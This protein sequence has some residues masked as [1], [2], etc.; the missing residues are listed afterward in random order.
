MRSFG[1]TILLSW[2]ILTSFTLSAQTHNWNIDPKDYGYDCEVNAIVFMGSGEVNTGT[3]G[4]FVGSTCRGFADGIY[5]S[6]TGKTIFSVRCYSD[7]TLLETITFRYFNPADNSYHNI[8]ETVTFVPDVQLGN[9][10]SPLLFHRCDPVVILSQPLNRSMCAVTGNESF[11]VTTGGDSP[12]TYQWQ[13][14]TGT[15]WINVANGAPTGAI[16]TGSN[17]TLLGL[18]GITAAGNYQYRCYI[19]NCHEWSN[20]TSNSATL[21]VNPLPSA[22]GSITGTA[23]VC[24]GNSALVYYVSAITNATSYIWTLPSGVTGTS[25]TNTITVNYSLTAVSGNITVRGHNDCGDGTPSLLAVT[26]NPLPVAASSISGPV[27]VCQGQTTVGYTVPAITN[28]ASY[29]WSYSGTGAVI[30]NGTTNSI[31]IDLATNATSGNLTVRGVNACGQG[32]VSANYPITVNPLPAAAGNI[33][34]TSI[35]CQGETSVGYSLSLVANA[36]SYSWT[37]SG[38]GA[39][40]NGTT[41][42][43]QIDFANNATSGI[44]TVRG[45]NA[46]GTGA[47]S[48][49]FPITVN[50]LPGTA[51]SITGPITICQGQSSVGY[52]VSSIA[53]AVSYAWTYSGTGAAINGT[54]NTVTIDF[55][56]TATP[57]NLIVRG[58]N[59]CGTGIASA[60]YPITVNLLPVAAGTITGLTT[61]CQGQSPVTY[62]VPAITNATTYIWTLPSGV[63]GTSTTNSITVSY[64]LSAISGNVSV[65]G[66]NACGDGAASALAVTV[67]PLPGAAGTMTGLTAVCQGQVSVNYTVPLIPNATTYIWTLP[68]GATGTSTTNSITVN[69]GLA[70]ISG[71]ITVRGHNACG[72][73]TL[74]T[75]ALTVNP[76]PLAAG[77]ITGLTTVCQGQSSVT[78]SV[79]TITN[80]ASYVWTVPTGATGTSTTNSIT[81]SYGINAISGNVTVRGHNACGDGTASALA[82]TVNPL[83]Q[84]AGTITGLTSVC[85]GQSL[86]T[87]TVPIITNATSYVWTLPSGSTGTS[88]TNSISVSYSLTA[89]SGNITVR[90][91]NGCGDGTASALAVTVNHLPSAI[92]GGNSVCAGSTITLG[93]SPTGGTW[94]SSVP[95]VAS[96]NSSTGLVAGVSQG[97]SVI[98][99]QLLSGCSVSQEINVL[100]ADW[101]F[102][103]EDFDYDGT[104]TALINMESKASVAGF[105]AAY[106]GDDCRGYAG[107]TYYSPTGNYIFKLDCFSNETTE[108]ILT[109]KYFD[110]VKNVVYNLDRSVNFAPGMDVGTE[111][112]PI[113]MEIGVNLN[114]SF[115]SGWTWF[116]VNIALDNMALNFIL[117]SV[118]TPG[119]YIKSQTS[120]ATYYAGYGWFGS[121]NTIEPTKLYKIKVQNTYAIKFSG[122]PVDV[123]T[124]P[125]SLSSGWNWIGY[126][127][128][129]S[130][131]LSTALASLPLANNDYIKDQFNSSTYYSIISDW[132]GNLTTMSPAAGYM[133][134]LT[135]SGTLQYP[136]SGKKGFDVNAKDAEN[137]YNANEFEF[138]GSL[139]VKVMLDGIAKGSEN[140]FLYAYVN[141]EIRG[142][143]GGDYFK[144]SDTW[145]YSLML[146]SNTS[147]GE[148]VKFRYFDSNSNKYYD[149]YETITFTSDMVIADALKPLELNFSSSDVRESFGED[150]KLR[151]YPNPFGQDLNI[152]YDLKNSCNVRITILDVYG[153][154]IRTLLDQTQ[155]PDN[156]LF[157]WNSDLPSYGIYF[158]RFEAGQ[159]HIIQKVIVR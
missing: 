75:L 119:D 76:L 69:Y 62:S 116:S 50:P 47:I 154:V 152:E 93:S 86:V 45:V 83:P 25:S 30:N 57:G 71:I 84:T 109:F 81:V 89:V 22:A 127:P 126:L 144:P 90:G 41:N 1:R 74:S 51:T 43:I 125:I 146:H 7:T 121:L 33:S 99:Y 147:Q 37:Y 60:S 158:I 85:R 105:L 26:V 138:N 4:A 20:L 124:T 94:S 44:L 27:S 145:L 11:S 21:T 97:V 8:D 117:S 18:S 2:L 153:R 128:Q 61:V 12:F 54:T 150:L 39:A 92:S 141:N 9:A 134:R 82:V 130:M 104:V 115:P 78:Y 148:I 79:P 65:R 53:N 135:N 5:F 136:E 107:S 29:S 55:S 139:T 49:N 140:D 31:I 48:A 88:I 132:F 87:Y 155:G 64:G 3:L 17:T 98:T 80:A 56:A 157:R 73:G 151:T 19:T 120:S 133:L 149:C 23:I 34:G 102:I 59:A 95:A 100:P 52:G 63:T 143:I 70:A 159:Q 111:S 40:I 38:N 35:V 58:V 108:D 131:P 24:Q 96:V 66:H 42:N 14:F 156:Y 118:A 10:L 101:S 13:Y 123:G 68:A 114:M 77:I 16:Y 72:D 106:S 129:N 110:P 122:K 15:D 142:V 113:I 137:Q 112:T 28:A 46:C 67:N 32:T 6:G 91:R 36:T 103:S